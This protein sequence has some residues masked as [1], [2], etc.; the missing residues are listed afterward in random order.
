MKNMIDVE[1]TDL[2]LKVMES[3]VSMLYAEPGFSDVDA[4]DIS[5]DIGISTKSVRGAL[6]SLVKKG[7]LSL[8]ENDSG[9]VIIYLNRGYW[10]LVNENWAAEA[11]MYL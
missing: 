1:L 2:E 8:D 6:G 7:I 11:N 9:Y 4:K 3:Y 5:E 10:Y